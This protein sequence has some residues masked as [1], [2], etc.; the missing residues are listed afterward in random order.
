MP[1][2]RKIARSAVI[3]CE[4]AS[5]RNRVGPQLA[6]GVPLLAI[7]AARTGRPGREGT[8][9]A[10]WVRA[11]HRRRGFRLRRLVDA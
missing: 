4:F 7:G 11:L 5:P 1:S 6:R 10:F 3:S 2:R 8:G 9:R